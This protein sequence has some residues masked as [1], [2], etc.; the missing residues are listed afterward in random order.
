VLEAHLTSLR[1]YE[2]QLERRA[3]ATCRIPTSHRGRAVTS[4]GR[5]LQLPTTNPTQGP[6]PDRQRLGVDVP[7]FGKDVL[8]ASSGL[9]ALTG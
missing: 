5:Y 2:D 8:A 6:H 7:T 1:A 3:Q 9:P 4:L